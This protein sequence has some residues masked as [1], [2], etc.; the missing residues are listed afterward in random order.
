MSLPVTGP[1]PHPLATVANVGQH[2]GQVV[3]LRGWLYNIRSSGKIAFPQL[4]DGSGVIQCVAMKNDLGDERFEALR[5]LGQESS[6]VLAGTVVADP[7]APGGYELKVSDLEVVQ[8]VEGFP[9]TPKEH[10][11]AFLHDNRH[12]WLRSKKQVALLRVRHLCVQAIRN[13]FDSRGFVLFDSPIFTPNACEGTTTLFATEYF[14]QTAYLSQSGQLYQEAGAMALGK[15]YCFGPTF[16][17]EKSATRRHLNEFWMV[18]PEVAYATLDDICD[19]AEDFLVEVVAHVLAHGRPWLEELERDISKLEAV[20]KPFHRMSYDEA[21]ARLAAL[22]VPVEP[23]DDFGSPHETALTEQF[24]RPIM[25]HRFPTAIKAF[26]M[27]EDPEN[28]LRALGVDVLAPEGY[29]EIIGGGERAADLDY[30]IEQLKAHNLPQET[31]EWYLDLR[32]YGSV[33][34][35][36]FGM[37]IERTVAWMCGIEHVRETI[38]F[39]RM[40]YRLRP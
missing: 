19:L 31:F 33:P 28:P 14:G 2:V 32:R 40:L 16:R 38:P 20:Q 39:P 35:A 22:G 26:Y 6:L 12:L 30:L 21:C 4:R 24:D 10:G 34:H 25:V 1:C 7:R 29:G 18:E 5:R 13:Y 3:T 9:I 11:P 17:A 23:E 27:K 8:A 37:G 36:G 15:T